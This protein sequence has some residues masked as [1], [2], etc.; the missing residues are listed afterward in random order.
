MVEEA[1]LKAAQYL[2]GGQQIE[3]EDFIPKSKNDFDQYAFLIASKYLAP[4][5]GSS[6][7]KLL[8]KQLMKH[9]MSSLNSQEVKDIETSI[10]GIRSDKLKEEKLAAGGKKAAKKAALNVG[11]SGGTAGLDD[12]VYDDLVEDEYD[13]M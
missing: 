2:F 12:Y 9:A 11:K 7:Y 8:M 13:F 4:H 5:A 10:A 1:D 6:N 3:L